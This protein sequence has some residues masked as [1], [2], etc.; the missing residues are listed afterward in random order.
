MIIPKMFALKHFPHFFLHYVLVTQRA[1][2]HSFVL[3]FCFAKA[4]PPIHV[5]TLSLCLLLSPLP[6]TKELHR[7]PW[8]CGKRLEV[9]L[10][11]ALSAN[12]CCK[13]C[14]PFYGIFL[15]SGSDL[16]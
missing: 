14:A 10:A 9:G 11:Q 2:E 3:Q 12:L 7:F 6:E 1:V 16:S 8:G 4:L 15:A 13:R 5:Y